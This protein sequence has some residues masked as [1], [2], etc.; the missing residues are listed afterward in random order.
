MRR[1]LIALTIA[2][3]F[4]VPA[5]ALAQPHGDVPP[6]TESGGHVSVPEGGEGH[7]PAEHGHHDD[8]TQHINWYH[9][10]YGKDVLGGKMGDGKLGER[11]LLPGEVEEP[12]GPPFLVMVLNFAILV[13]LLAKFGRPVAR[14]I[15]ETRSDAIKTA[16][17][18][19]ARLRDQ[20]QKKLDEYSEKLAA[21]DAEIKAMIDGMRADA[22]ADRKRVMADAEIQ[23]A[24]LKKEAEERI[25]AEIDRAR[26]A[27][28][29]EVAVAAAAA[30][31]KLIKQN[32]T[33]ADQTVLVDKF[34]TDVQASETRPS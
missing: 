11:A 10:H 31:E 22:E 3:G 8:P 34:I 19:A 28:G 12:M 15:S 24:A 4:A 14:K 9:L 26:H 25:A 6:T 16:L 29:R 2:A 27:L 5:V 18:E 1:P 23:A 30:A 20:A 21:A 7:G 17:D 33:N 13:L 32:L